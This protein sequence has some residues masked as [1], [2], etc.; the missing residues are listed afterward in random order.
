[1]QFEYRIGDN[2]QVQEEYSLRIEE[3][4]NLEKYNTTEKIRE[5]AEEVYKYL[6]T[7]V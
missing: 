7:A 5:L 3:A 4:C 2:E 1:M 6:L